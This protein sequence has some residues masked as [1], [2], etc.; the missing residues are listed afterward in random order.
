MC[1]RPINGLIPAL[2][3]RHS[4]CIDTGGES[5]K[6]EI[7]SVEHLTGEGQL[8]LFLVNERFSPIHRESLSLGMWAIS[9]V[10]LLDL[11]LLSL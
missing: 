1:K 2:A 8:C 9:L 4:M 10:W 7:V 5:N 11:S 6:C 3:Q